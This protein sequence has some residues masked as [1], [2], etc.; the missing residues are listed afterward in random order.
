MPWRPIQAG[1]RGFLA[2]LG[3]KNMG[4]LPEFLSEE[5]R[6]TLDM[7]GW[8]LR[9][10]AQIVSANE[11]VGTPATRAGA[12]LFVVPDNEWWYVHELSTR[13]ELA[14]GPTA[15][16][17]LGLSSYIQQRYGTQSTQNIISPPREPMTLTSIVGAV[18]FAAQPIRSIWCTPGARLGL[19][20]DYANI[21]DGVNP[22]P[23]IARGSVHYTPIRV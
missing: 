9:D 8:Y 20:T 4:S 13:I 16:D 5:V 23:G 12:Q 11:G 2:L 14:S 17:V 10:Q 21:E 1:A 19:H 6:P 22:P 15:F 18:T 3:L 7:E